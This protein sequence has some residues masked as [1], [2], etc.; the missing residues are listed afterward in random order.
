LGLDACVEGAEFLTG[1][2]EADE[3]DGRLADQ[4]EDHEFGLEWH[5]FEEAAVLLAALVQ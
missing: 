2:A 5:F 1:L 3:L 4:F